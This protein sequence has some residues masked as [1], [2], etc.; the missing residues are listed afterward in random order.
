MRWSGLPRASL[1][2]TNMRPE[3]DNAELL[4]AAGAQPCKG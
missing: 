2:S 3:H 4:R 1:F